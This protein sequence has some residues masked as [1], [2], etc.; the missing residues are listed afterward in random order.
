MKHWRIFN[1]YRVSIGFLLL[2]I[3]AV[4]CLPATN[5]TLITSLTENNSSD[6]IVAEGC[7]E[8]FPGSAIKV[9]NSNYS[10]YLLPVAIVLIVFVF[11]GLFWS[12]CNMCLTDRPS[13]RTELTE[14]QMTRNLLESFHNDQQEEKTRSGLTTF[15][16]PLF[17][18]EK[19]SY[20]KW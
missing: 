16:Q 14:D 3:L 15:N 8:G 6:P 18:P 20:L 9:D 5:E 2:A 19:G 4:N 11:F 17:V 7:F 1:V 13:N 12:L 10:K